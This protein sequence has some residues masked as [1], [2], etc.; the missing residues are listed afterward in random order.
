MGPGEHAFSNIDEVSIITVQV[1]S[2]IKHKDKKDG[3]NNSMWDVCEDGAEVIAKS[4]Q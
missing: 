3:N 2:D 4:L 1:Q